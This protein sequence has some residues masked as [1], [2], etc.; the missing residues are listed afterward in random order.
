MQGNVR[1][2]GNTW[3]YQF[4]IGTINGKKKYKS[5]GGFK[6]KGEASKALNQALCEFEGDGYIEP[7]GITF[8]T[9]SLKWLEEYVKP[10]RKIS[11]YNR[12]RELVKNYIIPYMGAYN[13]VDINAYTIEQILLNIKSEHDISGSTLQGIFTIINTI[14]NRALKLKLIKDNPCKFVERPKREKFIPDTL[15]ADEIHIIFN[16]LD[17]NTENDY[18]FF[19]GLRMVLELGLRRGELSGLEWR[20]INFAERT[21]KIVNNMVY[22]NGHLYLGTPKT[23]D[24]CRVLTISKNLLDLL[25]EFRNKQ[26]A[27]HEKYGQFYKPNIYNE[28][29]YDFIFRWS[30][31]THVH[32]MYF[33][34]KMPKMLKKC[35]INKRVR[36]HDSR[37]TNATLL[38]QGKT[39]LKTIQ[40]RLGHGDIRTTMNI[41]SH[42]TKEMQNNATNK[43]EEILKF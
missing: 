27:N 13:I 38:L 39:D 4:F 12:Y 18:I 25:N 26:F 36:F 15:T 9:V 32:P 3:S 21:I 31:G 23:D 33:T 17:L 37:H 42:V 34:N 16:N 40:E 6:T 8:E 14:M 10:L 28:K 7:S 2:R 11:T 43:M 19:I 5:K 41:Y 35:G 24:S 20:N 29:V 1:K 30:D 22:S